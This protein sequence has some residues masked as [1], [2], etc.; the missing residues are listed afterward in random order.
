MTRIKAIDAS[1]SAAVAAYIST[2][3]AVSNSPEDC[4]R[5]QIAAFEETLRA[6]GFVIIE[7][8]EDDACNSP[9]TSLQ[10]KR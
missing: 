9:S 1:I 5:A 7:R 3:T 2:E 6:N 10:A 4:L 8:S